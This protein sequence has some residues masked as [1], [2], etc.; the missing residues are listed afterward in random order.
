[1]VIRNTYPNH[2]HSSDFLF[3]FYELLMSLRIHNS[4]RNCEKTGTSKG[5]W[6]CLGRRM[7]IAPTNMLI[8]RHFRSEAKIL[9][10]KF[11]H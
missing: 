4:S 9:L 2:G 10:N 1:M 5:L 11:S 7:D 6:D 8:F 3:S